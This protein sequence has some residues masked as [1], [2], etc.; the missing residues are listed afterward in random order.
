MLQIFRQN[1]GATAISGETSRTRQTNFFSLSVDPARS[2]TSRRHFHGGSNRSRRS[3]RETNPSNKIASTANLLHM[4][5]RGLGDAEYMLEENAKFHDDCVICTEAFAND[6]VVCQLPCGHIHHSHCIL[7]WLHHN[8]DTCP[9]CR[10][11]VNKKKNAATHSNEENTDE[12]DSDEMLIRQQQKAV[13]QKNHNFDLIMRRI[14]R[15]QEEQDQQPQLQGTAAE[16][17]CD[18]DAD[19][20]EETITRSLND[21]TLVPTS[22]HTRRSSC[23]NSSVCYS[24]WLVDDLEEFLKV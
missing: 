3:R 18:F 6:D 20:F 2:V 19:C 21:G 15:A 14:L 17:H 24:D 9:T 1:T 16:D 10:Q 22:S 23:S 12:D 5:L 13:L 4:R 11:S 8:R 7:S